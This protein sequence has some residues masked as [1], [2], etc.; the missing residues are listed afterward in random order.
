MLQLPIFAMF[1]VK[2]SPSLTNRERPRQTNRARVATRGARVANKEKRAAKKEMMRVT[3]KAGEWTALFSPP[4]PPL[5]SSIPMFQILTPLILSPLPPLM[6]NQSFNQALLI[7]PQ[8][9]S[10]CFVR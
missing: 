4:L 10:C 3:T 6:L 2:V 5:Q 7:F 1:F 8:L 9:G